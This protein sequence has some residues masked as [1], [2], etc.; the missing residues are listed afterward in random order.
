MYGDVIFWGIAPVVTLG[1]VVKKEIEKN[2]KK[3]LTKEGEGGKIFE[4]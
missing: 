4:R 2:R 1:I 3:G